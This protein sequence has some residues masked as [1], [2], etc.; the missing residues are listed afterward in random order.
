[1][2]VTPEQIHA[3][4]SEGLMP[5]WDAVDQF[6][7]DQG[8][9]TAAETPAPAG[10]APAGGSTAETE[11]PPRAPESGE[12]SDPLAAEYG[13]FG[14]YLGDSPALY[15]ENSESLARQVEELRAQLEYFQQKASNKLAALPEDE[16]N[17]RASELK[18]NGK[19]VEAEKLVQDWLAA[20]RDTPEA[21]L[22]RRAQVANANI[23]AYAAKQ[24]ALKALLSRP[25]IGRALMR[26]VGLINLDRERGPELLHA[27]CLGL[28]YREIAKKAEER[29]RQSVQIKPAKTVSTPAATSPAAP[30]DDSG[31][32]RPR[33]PVSEQ[34]LAG[35]PLK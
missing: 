3:I 27:V 10:Q 15:K 34:L 8:T 13:A 31:K 30:R 5:N 1:M 17:A 33:I 23:E 18:E 35:K 21:F 28:C 4:A 12:V 22:Q 14:D 6:E 16:I 26:F 24:P 19:S 29:G 11:A 20:N 32:F 7:T 9:E 2:T 25:D